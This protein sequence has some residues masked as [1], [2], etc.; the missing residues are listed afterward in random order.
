M[1]DF[2]NHRQRLILQKV[3]PHTHARSAADRARLCRA[4]F[5]LPI[6][7][8]KVPR[9][10][11]AQPDTSFLTPVRST[12]EKSPLADTPFPADGNTAFPTRLS[13]AP[14]PGS[15]SGAAF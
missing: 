15:S 1:K 12:A 14:K 8:R 5:F 3:A 2:L 6:R 11:P 13:P 10:I 9:K 7:R 4:F